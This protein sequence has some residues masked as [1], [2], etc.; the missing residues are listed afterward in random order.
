MQHCKVLAHAY[1]QLDI[2]DK[3]YP[4]YD[5]KLA[6]VVFSM[7]PWRRYLYGVH[8]DVYTNHKSLQYVFTQTDLNLRQT[9]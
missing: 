6:A 4:T 8:V 3:N 1:R 2:H 9:K 5:L 7:K